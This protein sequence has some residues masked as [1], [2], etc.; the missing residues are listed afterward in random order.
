M[1]RAHVCHRICCT[2]FKAPMWG[3]LHALAAKLL[4]GHP[5]TNES[6]NLLAGTPHPTHFHVV[7]GGPQAHPRLIDHAL[8]AGIPPECHRQAGLPDPR[9][10]E[11]T[12]CHCSRYSAIGEFPMSATL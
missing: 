12:N 7:R 10:P 11:T 5:A 6:C 2:C 3:T 1:L 8:L 9:V 4:C